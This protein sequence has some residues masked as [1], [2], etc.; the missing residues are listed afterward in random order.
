MIIS[1]LKAELLF[2][3]LFWRRFL[4][5][6]NLLRGILNKVL[7]GRRS[8]HF[9]VEFRSLCLWKDKVDAKKTEMVICD[10]H[11]L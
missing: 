7:L 11:L 1:I 2:F 4:K 5:N 10:S 9:F 8:R 6:A 3:A